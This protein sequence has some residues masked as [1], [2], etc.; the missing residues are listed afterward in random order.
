VSSIKSHSAAKEWGRTIALLA[1]VALVTTTCRTAVVALYFVP[2]DS[3]VPT[4][5]PGDV[6][7]VSAGIHPSMFGFSLPA[8]ST[9]HRGDVIV[10][11][12]PGATVRD[13]P[14]PT[15]VKR[16]EGVAGDTIM[17]RHG[18]FTVN[19]QPDLFV[20][21]QS[22][23]HF[24]DLRLFADTKRWELRNTHYGEPTM[25]PTQHDWGPWIVPS[26]TVFVLGDNRDSAIDS[27]DFGPVPI[28]SVLGC[29]KY[30]LWAYDTGSHRQMRGLTAPVWVRIWHPV[31]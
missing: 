1:L 7:L 27:R 18:V 26:S 15:L 12:M 4:I 19:G 13:G 25:A 23:T 6:A 29:V 2:S 3:M 14:L 31:H 30:V 8:Y 16:V 28:K 17:M 9:I 20:P 24:I 22:E 10:F 5:H 21:R 11:S